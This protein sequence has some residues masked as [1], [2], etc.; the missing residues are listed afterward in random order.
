LS[1]PSQ[2][3][4]QPLLV[5]EDRLGEFRAVEHGHLLRRRYKAKVWIYRPGRI[6][7]DA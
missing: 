7:G 5:L 2:L 6:G 4:N 1:S 3:L